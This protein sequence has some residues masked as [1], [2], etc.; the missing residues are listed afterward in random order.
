[1]PTQIAG[2]APADDWI[3]FFSLVDK[4]RHALKQV[5]GLAQH[6]RRVGSVPSLETRKQ[7]APYSRASPCAI[8]IEIND[9]RPLA[10]DKLPVH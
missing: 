5:E 10:C 4:T 9:R 7:P 1:M 6:H 8:D 3:V 2:L